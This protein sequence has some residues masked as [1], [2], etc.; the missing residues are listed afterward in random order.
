[1]PEYIILIFLFSFVILAVIW[2]LKDP[3]KEKLY[4]LGFLILLFTLI[5]A[6]SILHYRIGG[7]A[8]AVEKEIQAI[9]ITKEDVDNTRDKVE[10]MEKDV[11][12]VKDSI[13]EIAKASAE[14]AILNFSHT[15]RLDSTE[16][17]MKKDEIRENLLSALE[18]LKV[19]DVDISQIE[20][21]YHISGD[22]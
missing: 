13:K 2:F 9:Q 17:T 1:M 12:A 5:Y 6:I 15:D 11:K 10:T 16:K 20:R 22:K 18:A 19:N 21:I 8:L 4:F 14:I 7:S 3:V